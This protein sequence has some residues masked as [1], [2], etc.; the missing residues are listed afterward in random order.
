MQA[1][2]TRGYTLLPC[3]CLMDSLSVLG[4][5]DI[6][7]QPRCDVQFWGVLS[8]TL[9]SSVF[10]QLLICPLQLLRLSTHGSTIF[11]GGCLGESVFL[12]LVGR[13]VA[14]FQVS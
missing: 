6:S 13:E 1:H 14:S 3:L 7:L 4:K 9:A 8:I 12:L 2:A 11:C 10:L 5:G